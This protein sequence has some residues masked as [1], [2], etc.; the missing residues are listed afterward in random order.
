[1]M[2]CRAEE[3]YQH[4]GQTCFL[5]LQTGGIEIYASTLKTQAWLAFEMLENSY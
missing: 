2:L 5:C 3:M 1:M 4:F